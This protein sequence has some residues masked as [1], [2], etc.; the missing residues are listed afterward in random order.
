MQIQAV[1]DRE[2]EIAKEQLKAGNKDKALFALR[3]RKYQESLLEKTDS[4][5]ENLE[6]LVCHPT[7]SRL[8]EH[9]MGYFRKGIDYRVLP[10]GGVSPA[11]LATR[12]RGL[13]TDPYR[14]EYRFCRK[15]IG[16]DGR[17]TGVST[18]TFC[19]TMFLLSL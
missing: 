3:R 10:G 5:L 9:L 2:H 13:E 7:V 11:W 18:S 17:G 4:Q 12:E 16:G 8:V 15:D 14:N 19:N 6:H 1:L